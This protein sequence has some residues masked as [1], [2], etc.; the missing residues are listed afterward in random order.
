MSS[1]TKPIASHDEAPRPKRSFTMMYDD[2][3]GFWFEISPALIADVISPKP[4]QDARPIDWKAVHAQVW[5]A[6]EAGNKLI[7]RWLAENPTAP[8]GN[9]PAAKGTP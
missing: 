9:K 6:L 5:A 3:R 7:A 4:T 8:A 1:R 2:N